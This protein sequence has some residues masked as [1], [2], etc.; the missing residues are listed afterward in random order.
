MSPTPVATSWYAGERVEL[1]R[2]R[3]ADGER[4][5]VG[6]RVWGV[7]RVTTSPPAVG[8]GATWSSAS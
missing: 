1:G 5:V 8:D 3:T 2:Y 6:Q 7:V 4:V